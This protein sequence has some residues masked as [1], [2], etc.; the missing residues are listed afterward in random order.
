[1]TMGIVW[2][3]AAILGSLLDIQTL[4]WRGGES[5]VMVA[6]FDSDGRGEVGIITDNTL[7]VFGRTGSASIYTIPLPAGTSAIDAI[8]VLIWSRTVDSFGCSQITVTSR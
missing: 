4:P 1:M 3:T 5:T 6:D 8:D 7:Q 2:A